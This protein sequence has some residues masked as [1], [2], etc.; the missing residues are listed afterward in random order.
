MDHDRDD[1][2]RPDDVG[3]RVHGLAQTPFHLVGL[4]DHEAPLLPVRGAARHA[5]GFE[6]P[7]LDVR[8]QRPV[9]IGADLAPAGD[10]EEDVHRDA[11]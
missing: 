6:D 2:R 5:P 9:R 1:E 11:A 10:R 4:D 3:R 7:A 8:G